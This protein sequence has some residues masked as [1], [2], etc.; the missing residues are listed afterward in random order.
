MCH[1]YI[2]IHTYINAYRHM[3]IHT[4]TYVHGRESPFDVPNIK[5][6]GM[7]IYEI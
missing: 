6:K 1:T 3:H 2:H 5:K 7:W 4:H